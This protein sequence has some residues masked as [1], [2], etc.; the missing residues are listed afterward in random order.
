MAFS[1]VDPTL[2]LIIEQYRSANL[3]VGGQHTLDI[4][5][6][7]CSRPSTVVTIVGIITSFI[8]FNLRSVVSPLLTT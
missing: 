3:P 6:V 5:L 1:G 4:V 2:P 8:A 7:L